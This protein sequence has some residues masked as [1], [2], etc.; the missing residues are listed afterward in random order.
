M[1]GQW[2]CS[3]TTNWYKGLMPGYLSTNNKLDRANKTL[4]DDYTLPVKL[5]MADLNKMQE[6]V[7]S[8][9]LNEGRDSFKDHETYCLRNGT[10]A[11]QWHTANPPSFRVWA[12]TYLET[13][14]VP[15]QQHHQE[16]AAN[17]TTDI[18]HTL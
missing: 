13:Y 17:W 3:D 1:Q 12:Q 15:A 10:D 8:W 2:I 4:K 6:A 16:F 14:L 11:W 18:R 5:G 9:F 7:T